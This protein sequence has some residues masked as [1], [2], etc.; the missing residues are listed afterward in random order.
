MARLDTG[1]R[2]AASAWAH[3]TFKTIPLGYTLG[4]L[5]DIGKG[6]SASSPSQDAGSGNFI[7]SILH[8][9]REILLIRLTIDVLLSSLPLLS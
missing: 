6:V 7:A 3:S 4:L 9:V 8:S 1:W 2:S 5:T